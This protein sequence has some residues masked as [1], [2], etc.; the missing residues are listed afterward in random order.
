MQSSPMRSSWMALEPSSRHSGMSESGS[1]AAKHKALADATKTKSAD[2]LRRCTVLLTL[3][4][5]LPPPL[6]PPP[7]LLLQ[8]ARRGMRGHRMLNITGEYKTTN[9]F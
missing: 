9:A 6:P 1:P 3:L 7:L 4:L 2:G 8:D 5:H